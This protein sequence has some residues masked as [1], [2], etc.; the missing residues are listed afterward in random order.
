ML[1]Y[2][3]V[4]KF[5]SGVQRCVV[6]WRVRL[7]VAELWSASAFK[8]ELCQDKAEFGLGGTPGKTSS[9]SLVPSYPPCSTP[10]CQKVVQQAKMQQSEQYRSQRIDSTSQSN[11]MRCIFREGLKTS[12]QTRASL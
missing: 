2:N 1:L 6:A 8:R 3:K 11:K 9:K 7:F 12:G 4:S 5:E 10:Q